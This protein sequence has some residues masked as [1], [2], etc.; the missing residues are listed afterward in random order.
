MRAFAHLAKMD[1]S[2][3]SLPLG[4]L[5]WRISVLIEAGFGPSVPAYPHNWRLVLV[6]RTY[7]SAAGSRS[8]MEP[9]SV[10]VAGAFHAAGKIRRRRAIAI[11]SAGTDR[12]GLCLSRLPGAIDTYRVPD[13]S[14]LPRWS[15]RAGTRLRGHLKMGARRHTGSTFGPLANHTVHSVSYQY[16]P[17]S[18]AV[19]SHAQTDS[20]F[21]LV[22]S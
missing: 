7:C 14:G 16:K 18:C 9:P 22:A 20:P 19:G 2:C 1:R 21:A 13:S 12:V 15:G 4:L 10:R 11:V 5:R 17:V 8:V 6:L 3:K